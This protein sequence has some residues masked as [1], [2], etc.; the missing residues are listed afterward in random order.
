MPYVKVT[1]SGALKQNL[2]SFKVAGKAWS[3]DASGYWLERR[4]E[5]REY[6]SW[7]GKIGT[8]SLL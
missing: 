3:T 2:F 1:N 7:N 6:T 4:K 8:T 5:G